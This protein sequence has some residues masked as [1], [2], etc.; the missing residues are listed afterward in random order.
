[1]TIYHFSGAGNNFVVLDGRNDDMSEY[2]TPGRIVALCNQYHTDGLMILGEDRSDKGV[3]QACR[4]HKTE[5]GAAQQTH[6]I[7]TAEPLCPEVEAD[8]TMEFYNPD[9]SGGMMCGNGGRCIA[10][11]ADYLGIKP[12]D[13]NTFHFLAPDGP[14]T[15]ELLEKSA[16]GWTIR[17]QMKD[18]SGVKPVL[19]GY[20]LDTG[21]RHYVRFVDDVEAIDIDIE[22]PRYRH[23]PAFA[24]VGA[25][26]NFVQRLP[27]GGIKV[28][29]FE[30]GVEG[31]TL[32]CGTGITA[33]AIAAW[34]DSSRH[35]RPDRASVHTPVRA[36]QDD[37]CV[38]FLPTG[39]ATFT[40]VFLTGPAILLAQYE[41]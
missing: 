18:V 14:H 20:F 41:E 26:A 2:R 25:N 36:R 8:F 6:E 39:P 7:S 23:D 37:L 32:A 10:A 24:P 9:G 3:R 15:A 13:G 16:E 29:T 40:S 5:G 27:G 33:S 19:G 21:T 28:R 4:L 38:D 22:G 31:E 11:F 34:Y 1:M 12:S 17:L 35:A 30:K